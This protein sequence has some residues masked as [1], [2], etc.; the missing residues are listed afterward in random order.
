VI[1][2]RSAAAAVKVLAH[3]PCPICGER[4]AGGITFPAPPDGARIAHRF[5]YCLVAPNE[6]AFS[7][8]NG[9]VTARW[10]RKPATDR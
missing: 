4:I 10:N 3:D 9:I 1:D 8:E 5:G 2:A 6:I 7:H